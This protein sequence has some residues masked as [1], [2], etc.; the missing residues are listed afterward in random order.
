[1]CVEKGLVN[2][3]VAES[4]ES[5]DDDEAEEVIQPLPK[6]KQQRSGVSAES[7]GAHNKKEDFVPKV[8]PKNDEQKNRIRTKLEK[9]FMFQAL[10]EKEKSIVV[11]AMEERVFKYI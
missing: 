5:S 10:D 11:D 1:M 2:K 7:Y 9:A 8:I 3:D 4:S 6:G